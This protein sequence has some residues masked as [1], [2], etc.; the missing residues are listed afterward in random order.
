MRTET[1][2][3]PNCG[4]RRLLAEQMT[5]EDDGRGPMGR[6][7]KTRHEIPEP[8]QAGNKRDAPPLNLESAQQ[9]LTRHRVEHGAQNDARHAEREPEAHTE[10]RDQD[11][12]LHVLII[13]AMLLSI[14]CRWPRQPRLNRN[15]RSS[16]DGKDAYA[17]LQHVLT[18][19]EDDAPQRT[20]IAIVPSPGDR[21][22][23]TVRQDV[24]GG[25][26]VH[27]AVDRAIDG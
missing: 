27:P 2:P 20:D 16:G 1:H 7:C 17:H 18:A 8:E 14:Q 23:A 11:H 19:T 21:H 25:I 12:D 6:R 26:E 9:P 10:R 22:M 3:D 24:I 13:G 15:A 4:Q 5:E